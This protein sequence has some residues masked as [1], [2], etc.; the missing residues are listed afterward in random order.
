M[1][2]LYV[3]I[4]AWGAA[5]LG[6]YLVIYTLVKWHRAARACHPMPFRR[7]KGYVTGLAFSAMFVASPALVHADGHKIQASITQFFQA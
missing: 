1:T 7:R 2:N 6:I 5:L 3:L 4:A